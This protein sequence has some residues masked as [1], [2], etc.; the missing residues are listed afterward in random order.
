MP[1]RAYTAGVGT[2]LDAKKVLQLITGERK[3]A[4]AAAAIEGP[5]TA[6][7]SSTALQWHPDTVIILDEDAAADLKLKDFYK[8][9]FE[10]DP[11]WARY[12]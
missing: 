12:R 9:I 3:A 4:I 2:V 7:I 5:M 8:E 10:N 11:K 1:R 6:M